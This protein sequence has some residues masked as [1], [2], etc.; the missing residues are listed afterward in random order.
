MRRN[1]SITLNPRITFWIAVVGIWLVGAAAIAADATGGP[2]AAVALLLVFA[3]VL[4][5][6]L[7]YSDRHGGYPL[8]ALG[9]ARRTLLLRIVV[10]LS[11][12]VGPV[13]LLD[14]ALS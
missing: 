10:V 9:E 4:L 13:A 5:D 8:W 1:P 11:V 2:V 14:R 7:A 3:L 6:V 12:G